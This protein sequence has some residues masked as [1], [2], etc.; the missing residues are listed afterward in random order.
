MSKAARPPAVPRRPCRQPVAA[1]SAASG[2]PRPRA[3]SA[4]TTRDSARSRTAASAMS[5]QVAGGCGL[6][7]VTD[8]EFRRG[9]YWGRFVERIDGFVIKPASF[10]FR[11]DHGHEVEFTAPYAEA[12]DRSAPSRW[13]S[14]NSIPARGHQGDAE[15]HAAG[16]LDHAFLP[17]HR[18]RRRSPSTPTSRAFFADLARCSARRSPI[19]PRP[20]AAISSSTRLRSRCC[21]I[22]R[23]ASKVEAAAMKPDALVDLYIEA[24]NRLRRRG[25]ADVVFGVHMCRGNFKGHY[26]A[27]GGYESVAE[28]FFTEHQGQS[29]PAR[30]RHRAR[31]RL[32]AAALRPKGKGV[33]LGLVSSKTAGAGS[34]DDAQAPH[35]RGDAIHRPRPARDQP[36]MRLC[37]DGRRQSGDGSD[38]RAKLELV[39]NAAQA[40]WG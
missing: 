13:R 12:Q 15:D 8:G 27:A 11:D 28:R 1:A 16:A 40:I 24:I 36:A 37:L 34:L 39:V 29:L 21:A 2:L 9:S 33:V 22:R 14:T 32:R 26:L 19:W 23:S 38:E 30:I 6:Q 18:F 35:R 25:P 5:V 31:R 7:V 10:K 17:L 4:S 3:A 20:A